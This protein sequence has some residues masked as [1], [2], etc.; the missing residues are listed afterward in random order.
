[1]RS[2]LRNTI[3]PIKAKKL[4]PINPILTAENLLGENLN[5]TDGRFVNKL[6]KPIKLELMDKMEMG[7]GNSFIYRFALPGR[8]RCLG[9]H[10]CQYL[11]LSANINGQ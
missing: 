8:N 7:V 6:K 2:L 5:E 10:T 3:L 1:M 9:H 4:V 11:E